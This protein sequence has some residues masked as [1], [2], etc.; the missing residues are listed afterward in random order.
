VSDAVGGCHPAHLNGDFP[1]FRAVIDFRKNMTMNID[2][3]G[4]PELH[5]EF[6]QILAGKTKP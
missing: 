2:Q 4:R 5:L 3:S 1:R 6:N